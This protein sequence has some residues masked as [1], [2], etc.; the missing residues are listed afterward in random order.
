MNNDEW[1]DK[2]ID[3]EERDDQVTSTS[4]DHEV[5][6]NES[7]E[8][9]NLQLELSQDDNDAIPDDIKVPQAKI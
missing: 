8:T 9:L 4:D 1:L 5:D 3:L 6:F 7:Q 2:S